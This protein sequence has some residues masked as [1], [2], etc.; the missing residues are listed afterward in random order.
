MA[1]LAGDVADILIERVYATG[2][3][4]HTQTFVISILS[5][6]QR[7][8]NTFLRSVRDSLALNVLAEKLIYKL[9]DD[10]PAAIDVTKVEESR[11]GNDEQLELV[12]DTLELSGYD[13]DWFRNI[14]GSRYET[15]S[16]IGRDLLVLY[17]A[18]AIAGIATIHYTKLT[19]ALAAAATAFELPDEDV[20]VASDLAEIILLARDKQIVECENKLE[21]AIEYLG[22][23]GIDDEERD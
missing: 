20:H 22:I 15:W 2:G 6:T 18:K 12:E 1:K 21:Q 8:A 4:A 5:K 7:V 11:G 13:V 3:I 10:V 19:T 16:Q 14:T 23:E 17:P 9:R